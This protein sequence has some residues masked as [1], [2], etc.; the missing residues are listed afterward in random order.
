[1]LLLFQFWSAFPICEPIALTCESDNP[2]PPQVLKTPSL[3]ESVFW[4]FISAH[5]TGLQLWVCVFPVLKT[6]SPPFNRARGTTN[7]ASLVP[8]GV[9][10][11][12]R[13]RHCFQDP[14]QSERESWSVCSS[15]DHWIKPR[16]QGQRGTGTGADRQD[17]SDFQV[18]PMASKR[19]EI[20]VHLWMSVS[21]LQRL[22]DCRSNT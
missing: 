21:T 13:Q 4:R 10:P 3:E 12:G 2:Y 20:K 6:N 19:R 14:L 8:W 7:S 5:P 16:G 9:F 17:G 15:S 22:T 18:V 11:S 1:M